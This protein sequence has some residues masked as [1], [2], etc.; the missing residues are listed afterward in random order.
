MVIASIK[1][2]SFPSLEVAML[3]KVVSKKIASDCDI[4]ASWSVNSPSRPAL[5][6]ENNVIA[7]II[8][9]TLYFTVIHATETDV[10]SGR[11]WQLLVCNF[12][13][14]ETGVSITFSYKRPLK[15]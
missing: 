13:Y 4:L 10:S 3:A 5:G 9:A 15:E 11:A 8:G 7:I 6:K 14:S 2:I 1:S 12:G